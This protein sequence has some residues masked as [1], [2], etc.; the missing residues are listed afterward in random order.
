MERGA[1]PASLRG[2]MLTPLGDLRWSGLPFLAGS[3]FTLKFASNSGCLM[4]K[5]QLVFFVPES[6]LRE[7]CGKR[8]RG[9]APGCSGLDAPPRGHLSRGGKPDA[10]EGR[11]GP[12]PDGCPTHAWAR[13]I[14]FRRPQ[15][16][17][18]SAPWNP[19]RLRRLGMTCDLRHR[20]NELEAGADLSKTWIA[21][22]GHGPLDPGGDPSHV[23]SSAWRAAQAR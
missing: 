21:P 18:V 8:E 19:H 16:V 9:V 3:A 4:S 22:P 20:G 23:Q 11:F 6:F 15:K 5:K 2:L 1:R 14:T 17:L 13:P 12:L 7:V 10:E